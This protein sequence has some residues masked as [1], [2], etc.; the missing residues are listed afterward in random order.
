MRDKN[1]I[2]N[3]IKMDLFRVVTAAGDITKELPKTSIS[4]FMTHAIN[5]FN[6]VELTPREVELKNQLQLLHA[7][8]SKISD[9]FSRLRWTEDVL[10][11]R[12]RI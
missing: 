12:C 9:P 5:D 8:L 6:K 2:I 11:V 4:E 10:T 3:S 1:F 7:D